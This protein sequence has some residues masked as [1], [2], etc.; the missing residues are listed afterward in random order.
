MQYP[1][2]IPSPPPH[3]HII[4]IVVSS[5]KFAVIFYFVPLQTLITPNPT[6]P[7]L[8]FIQIICM[9]SVGQ[10]PYAESLRSVL[11]SVSRS[12]ERLGAAPPTKAFWTSEQYLLELHDRLDIGWQSLS[13]M[14]LTFGRFEARVREKATSLAAIAMKARTDERATSKAFLANCYLN[15]L[16]YLVQGCRINMSAL[17]DIQRSIKNKLLDVAGAT[18]NLQA[19]IKVASEAMRML[20]DILRSNIQYIN[21]NEEG[22]PSTV[23]ITLNFCREHVISV[24]TCAD[25]PFRAF[26]FRRRLKKLVN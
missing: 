7:S 4:S 18:E 17:D 8:L 19:N 11:F 13:L 10:I 15:I 1:I 5:S 6:Q 3:R 14:E 24:K 22:I 2:P 26:S 9:A 16:K 23:K 21:T 25:T 12:L 20:G